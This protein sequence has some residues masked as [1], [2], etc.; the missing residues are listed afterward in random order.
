MH[1]EVTIS[2]VGAGG[3]GVAKTASGAVCVPFALPGEV[4]NIARAGDGA[5]V[6]ALKQA[7]PARVV[8]PCQYFE[9]CGGCVLQHWRLEEY[10]HWKRELVVTALQA[11]GLDVPVDALVPAH[12]CSRRRIMLSARLTAKGQVVGFNRYHSHDVVEVTECP[13]TVAEITSRFDDLRLVAGALSGRNKMLHLTVTLAGNGLDIAITGA[14]A[15]EEAERQRLVRLCLGKQFARIAVDGEIIVE[16]EKPRLDFGG[17]TVE[18]PSG[19]FLQATAEAENILQKLVLEGLGKTRQALDLFAGVGTFTFP[20]AKRMNVH[21]VEFDKP[22]LAA[23]ERAARRATGLKKFSHEQRDLFRR[24]LSH[25]EI[26]GFDGLVFDPPRAGAEAQVAEIARAIVPR[27]VAVSCN[28]VTLARDL[29]I[30][31]DGGYAIKRIVP[32]DQFLWTPHV[33]A[34]AFL[35]RRRPKPGWKL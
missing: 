4:V 7:S 12:A 29:K 20:M 14:K 31:V 35:A 2:A 5:L 17:V 19:G 23:M 10:Q 22:A 34:V 27:V 32:V 24:P 16:R 30:L 21:A 25:K 15:L 28:P 18:I 1:E 6:M 33:E 13:V 26:A 8:P 11:R 9:S 3:E